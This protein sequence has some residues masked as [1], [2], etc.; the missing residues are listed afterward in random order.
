MAWSAE[1]DKV[2]SG[3]CISGRYVSM[4]TWAPMLDSK[5][6]DDDRSSS[7]SSLYCMRGEEIVKVDAEEVNLKVSGEGS[8]TESGIVS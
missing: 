4:F 1:M 7:T 2:R 8:M 3:V 5:S 6:K